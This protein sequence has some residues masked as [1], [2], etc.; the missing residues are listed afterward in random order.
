LVVPVGKFGRKREIGF[1]KTE[2]NLLASQP[3]SGFD[4]TASG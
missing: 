2:F 3:Q 4:L 1:S